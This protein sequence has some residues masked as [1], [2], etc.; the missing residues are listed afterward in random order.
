MSFRS[1]CAPA[2]CPPVSAR[3]HLTIHP[4]PRAPIAVDYSLP[5]VGG[6][7]H[8]LAAPPVPLPEACAHQAPDLGETGLSL[9][10][11]EGV[12]GGATASQE[13]ELWELSQW[14]SGLTVSA[15]QEALATVTRQ[16]S[17]P[18]DPP[19]APSAPAM[20]PPHQPHPKSAAP[21]LSVFSDPPPAAA[22][23]SAASGA[24]VPRHP[25]ALADRTNLPAGGAAK[26]LKQLSSKLHIAH[27]Q[28][29]ELPVV[30]AGAGGGCWRGGW[31]VLGSV[32]CMHLLHHDAVLPAQAP[33]PSTPLHPPPPPHRPT[34]PPTP[35]PHPT[36]PPHP[37]ARPHAHA[38]AGR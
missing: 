31:W 6:G 8:G 12:L 25:A 4:N 35:H 37:P 18:T 15:K 38:A 26:H 3:L 23:T 33:Q 5:L 24:A 28:K 22:P 14:F 16:L 9:E 29:M 19:P 32:C 2:D 36:P 13:A 17:F 27:S 30:G 20:P 1:T 7:A 21:A 11:L 34:H 10:E